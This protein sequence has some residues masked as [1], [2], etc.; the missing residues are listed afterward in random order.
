M[1]RRILKAVIIFSGVMSCLTMPQDVRAGVELKVTQQMELDGQPLDVASSADGKLIFVLVPGEV[2]VYAISKKKV[3]NHIPVNK[4]FNRLGYTARTN[5]LV[6]TS[7]SAKTLKIIK[8][9]WIYSMDV[10]GLPFRGPA[11]APVTVAVF[12]DYQ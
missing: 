5:T 7:S 12:S 1:K 3:T 10:S 2:L 6:L 11:D 9:E 8:L 4:A